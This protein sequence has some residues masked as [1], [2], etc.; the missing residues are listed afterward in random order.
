MSDRAPA[1]LLTE[2]SSLLLQSLGQAGVR[3]HNIAR[4][5]N[6]SGDITKTVPYSVIPCILSL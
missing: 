6:S 5:P 3:D 4:F 1:N 2:W